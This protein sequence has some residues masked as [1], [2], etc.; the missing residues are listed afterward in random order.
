MMKLLIEGCNDY[1]V[2]NQ[3]PSHFFSFSHFLKL[4]K[5]L[6]NLKSVS[7]VKRRKLKSEIILWTFDELKR[8]R[9]MIL[10]LSNIF[11]SENRLKNFFDKK[12]TKKNSLG[13]LKILI[14]APWHPCVHFRKYFEIS[15]SPE[16]KKVFDFFF[17]SIFL[18]K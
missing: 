2:Q 1:F 12:M 17:I 10:S 5:Y 8:V 16:K 3:S 14:L 15:K 7:F 13:L 9:L 6:N 11:F 4:F 18:K